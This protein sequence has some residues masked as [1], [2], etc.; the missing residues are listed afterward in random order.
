[1][2]ALRDAF[3]GLVA[4]LDEE[5]GLL[6]LETACFARLC[7][8]AIDTGDRV[9]VRRCFRLA[10]VAAMEG[11]A[12][13]QNAIGV[14]FIEHLNF[15]DGKVQRRWAYDLLPP[16]LQADAVALGTAPG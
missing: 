10:R 3:P 16:R 15:R 2:A 14:S 9:L 11:D 5:D 7:Q 12:G 6:H 8:R 1:M 4:E 13:V